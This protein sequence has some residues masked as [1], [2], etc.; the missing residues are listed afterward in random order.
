MLLIAGLASLALPGTARS[1]PEFLVLAG[2]YPANKAVAVVAT[3]G[4]ILAAGYVC[5]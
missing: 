4:I 5:G 2:T 3:I 1:S